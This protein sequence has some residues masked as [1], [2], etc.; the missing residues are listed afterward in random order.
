MHRITALLMKENVIIRVD[1]GPRCEDAQDC[2]KRICALFSQLASLDDM[3]EGWFRKAGSPTLGRR[4]EWNDTREVSQFLEAS[5]DPKDYAKGAVP[6][7]GFV[8]DLWNGNYR[9]A[10]AEVTIACGGSDKYVSNSCSLNLLPS[11]AGMIGVDSI[12]RLLEAQVAAWDPDMGEVFQLVQNGDDLDEIVCAGY[13]IKPER[14]RP[15]VE[16]YPV[17]KGH[18]WVDQSAYDRFT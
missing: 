5:L 9:S 7:L 11:E 10:G 2:A 13:S 15:G 16:I 14:R 12:A 3:F 1:W 17:R 4:L 8:V 6:L 18:I